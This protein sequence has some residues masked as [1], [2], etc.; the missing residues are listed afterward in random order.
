MCGQLAAQQPRLPQDTPRTPQPAPRAA[1]LAIDRERFPDQVP[2]GAGDLKLRL[3]AVVL[4]GNKALPSSR[5]APL[6]ESLLGKEVT[7]AAVFELAAAISAEYRRAGFVLSQAFVPRQE[8][9]QANGR[10][11]I[12]VSEGFVGLVSLSR[13]VPGSARLLGMMEPVQWERPLTLGTLERRLLLLNDL[14]GVQAR[15]SI[16]AGEQVNATNLELQVDRVTSAFSL[17]VHNRTSEAVGPVRVEASAERR[18]LLGD[19]DRHALRWVGSGN[20][21]LNLLAYNGDQPLGHGGTVGSWSASISKSKPKSGTVF[22]LDTDSTSGSLGL[23]HPL[24]RSRAANF[25][26]RV[27]MASYDGSS[28]VAGGLQLSAESLRTVRAGFSL[29]FVDGLSGVNLFDVEVARGTTWFGASR[30]GDESLAR[31]DSN[32]QFTKATIYAARLQSLGG[33]WSVLAAI[34][35]QAA[36]DL[37][38]SSEQFSLGGDVFLRAYDPSELLGD[39]GAAAKFELRYNAQFGPAALATLYA[40]VEAGEVKVKSVGGPSTRERAGSSGLGVRLSGPSGVRGYVELA[41]PHRKATAK[42]GDE[43]ARAFAGIGIDF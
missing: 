39:T 33:E 28:D 7:L 20:Q 38:S 15:A 10:V 32:P 11:S 14:P 21:R 35:G 37:L 3:V 18:G 6:W 25:T 4:V 41:K 9:D 17:S 36:D 12:R 5:F 8:I 27:A 40:F 26:A 1:P 2:P 24:L 22:Q 13:E 19:F 30:P 43:S 34:T 42:N 31:S 16:R 29:D 23:S